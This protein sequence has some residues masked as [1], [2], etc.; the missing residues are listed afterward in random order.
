MRSDWYSGVAEMIASLGGS[1]FPRTMVGALRDIAAFEY[2]VIFGYVGDRRPL[3]LYDDFPLDRQRLHVGD[4]LEGPYFLDPFFLA[5]RDPARRGLYRMSEIAPDR[6][7]QGEY[8]KNYYEQT[9]LAEEIGYLATVDEELTLVISLM[10][11][12]RR[13]TAAEFRH[14]AAVWPVVEAASRHQWQGTARAAHDASDGIEAR[15]N[16]A[17][18]SIGE[19][20]LTAREREVVEFTLKGHSADATGKALGISP[21]TVRIHRRNIYAKLRISSQGEL[22][23]AFIG[24][25]VQKNGAARPSA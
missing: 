15:V 16:A 14:L 6:F 8:F 12:E 21:G 23:S 10:R 3:A 24:A 11:A 2:C 7:Y 9:G 17:F 13:F 1:S 5:S 19:G 25:I 4:Y 22:F 18:R 20:V